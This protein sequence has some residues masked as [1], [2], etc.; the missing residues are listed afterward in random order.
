MIIKYV[1][2]EQIIAKVMADAN[3]KEVGQRISDIRE[4][5]FEAIDKIGAATQYSYK[6]SGV[7][8]VPV[9]QI[10]DY[11]AQLPSDLVTLKTVAYSK[12][13]DGPWQSVR[14]NTG[15][16][17]SFPDK[18]DL[19]TNA[20]VATEDDNLYSPIIISKPGNK[21]MTNYSADVQYFVKPGY[22]VTT[23]REGYLKIAYSA[24][25]TDTRGYPLVPDLSSYSEAIYWYVLMKL[26]Y[27]EYLNGKLRREI[28]YD[29]QNSWN[30]YRKQAY[31]EALMPSEDEMI[32]I[33][34]MWHRLVPD[35]DSDKTFYSTTGQYEHVYNNYYGR[36]Y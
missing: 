2:C 12:N 35:Y 16:F 14:S 24:I 4:W 10:K 29:I 30:F 13:I 28:Y 22:I 6:E 15:S 27:P 25:L 20:V 19:D 11:Q 7:E 17:K 34:N 32:S 8:N 3:I 31:A 1:P 9:L 21:N 18:Y 5:I 23:V 36:I 26:K 33:K